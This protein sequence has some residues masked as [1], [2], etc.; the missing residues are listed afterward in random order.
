MLQNLP[1]EHRPLLVL[2]AVVLFMLALF[3]GFKTWLTYRQAIQVDKPVP[4]EYTISVE[5]IGTAQVKPDVARVSFSIET[6]KP[7]LAESQTENTATMNGLLEKLTGA[8]V[9]KKDVQTTSYNSYEDKLYDSQNAAYKSYGWIMSQSV[10]VT[11]RDFDKMPSVLGVIG[12]NGATNISGPNFQVESD[13]VAMQEARNLALTDAKAK[14]DAISSKLGIMLG[15]PTSYNEWKEDNG[16]PYP[17]ATMKAEGMGGGEAP[18]EP[19][20]EPGQN[21]LKLHVSLSYVI[22]R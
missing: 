17:Y 4:Y 21:N 14:A 7:T 10:T 3:L 2:M 9:E 6:R 5:G 22:K 16:G 13:T 8:G 19:T 11:L 1:H 20:V 12:Q 15:L 18:S